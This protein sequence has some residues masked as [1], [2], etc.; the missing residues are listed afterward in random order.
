MD[1]RKIKEYF[2]SHGRDSLV[3]EN[4]DSTNT[5]LKKN[6]QSFGTLALALS[7]SAGHGQY[8]RV[9][10]SPASGLYMSLCVKYI[11]DFPMT[12]ASANAAVDALDELFGLKIDVK[13]VNDLIV[14]SR[15]LCGILA[16]SVFC[17]D[18]SFT[19]IGFG[20]N[21]RKGGLSKE[22]SKIAI[23]LEEIVDSELPDDILP[24]LA[25]KIAENLEAELKKSKEAVIERYKQICISEIP[26][27][28]VFI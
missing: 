22:I 28:A 16:E 20:M 24:I 27:N 3:F 5:Y 23:S 19:V 10:E 14:S 2:E 7:Q 26:E 12:L 17:G 13:W 25:L 11:P 15:K 18:K 8:E 9:F 21:I 4:I 6:P 1:V